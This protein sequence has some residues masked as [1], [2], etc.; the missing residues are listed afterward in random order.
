MKDRENYRT[1]K[2]PITISFFLI[3]CV[4]LFTSMCQK[5]HQDTGWL[6]SL[7]EEGRGIFYQTIREEITAH[8]KQSLLTET[9]LTKIKEA[10]TRYERLYELLINIFYQEGEPVFKDLIDRGDDESKSRFSRKYL[11]LVRFSAHNFV[12]CFFLTDFSTEFTRENIPAYKDMDAVDLVIRS[13]GYHAKLDIPEREMFT[14]PLSP[15]FDK[16][17]ALDGAKFRDAHEITKGKGAKIAI[18]DTGIDE[19]HSI[20]KNTLWGKHFSL[21]GRTGKPWDTDAP[22]I[23]WGSH[24]TL[25]T[26]IAVRYAP[27]AQITMYKFGDGE[28]QNDPPYQLLMQCIVAASIYKAVNDG[29]DIISLS[30]SGASLDSD[31]LREACQYA[32]E[33][34]RIVI[35]G[36]LYS[37]WFKKGNVLNFPS[38]YETVVS[39]TAAEKHENGTYGYWDVC[40]PGDTTTVAAPNDIFGAFPTYID[41]EDRY[42]PSISAA[43]PVVAA[44]FALII[45]EYPRLGTESPGEYTDAIMKLVI[46][47][48]NPQ[49]VGFEGFSPECGYGMIDAERTVKSAVLLNKNRTQSLKK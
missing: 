9:E 11:D 24:G 17:G 21:V 39:V 48:A 16:Q 46:E 29:N 36:N 32:Y 10:E 2:K 45:S 7:H 18:L 22:V 15:E 13:T 27:E 19:S 33:N 34:N 35:S 49:I 26:S 30:A 38:Q 40:A 28:T 42:I 14:N 37:R 20:F 25:I 43:I 8:P 41:E 12:E 31:Y 6:E 4:L 5:K 44:L 23:D 1:S 47:N 3:I